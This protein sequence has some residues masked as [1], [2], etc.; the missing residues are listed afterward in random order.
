MTSSNKKAN[1]VQA[2]LSKKFVAYVHDHP[3]HYPDPDAFLESLKA[4][5]EKAAR[6]NTLV[7]SL[8]ELCAVWER[9][10]ERVPWCKD[11]TYFSYSEKLGSTPEHTMGLCYIGDPSAM[12]V[13]ECLEIKP[14]S[15]VVDMCAAPGGKSS[16][17]LNYLGA[18]GT[19]IAND[20]DARRAKVLR[21]NLERM[22]QLVP[23][24]TQP[25]VIVTSMS[26][27]DLAREYESRADIVIL[28]APCSGE[29]MMRRSNIAR[30]QWS[31]KLLLKMSL[32][33]KVLLAQAVVIA[34]PQAQI[35][36]A[37]CTFNEQENDFVVRFGIEELGLNAR[38]GEKLVNGLR[39]RDNSHVEG[40]TVNEL[41]LVLYPH[42]VRGDG[43]SV[44]V[45]CK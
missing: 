5:P 42:R 2:S 36:Y 22:V 16:H 30:R 41:G 40:T 29:A 31:E 7:T 38:S 45:L 8:D 23:S 18:N 24:E 27:Q 9:E 26:A 37:T 35:G 43:Q 21:E 1:P 19:L 44:A 12:L 25:R 34:Q 14:D 13:V 17:V 10:V 4:W 15:F 39:Q 33:Q 3:D 11:A 6:A 20:I 32:V 28:D